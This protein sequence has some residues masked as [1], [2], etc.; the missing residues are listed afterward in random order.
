[1]KSAIFYLEKAL[2]LN[3]TFSTAINCLYQSYKQLQR[4]EEMSKLQQKYP[5]LLD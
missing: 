1:M 4:K 5:N 2:Q 3:V